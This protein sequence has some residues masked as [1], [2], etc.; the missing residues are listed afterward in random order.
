M[1]ESFVGQ[2]H[3]PRPLVPACL[4]LLLAEHSG[5]GYE[6]FDRLQSLGLQLSTRGSVY[7]YLRMLE[8]ADLVSSELETRESGPC[9]IVYRPTAV[10]S[11]VVHRCSASGGQLLSVLKELLAP[12]RGAVVSQSS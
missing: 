2:V 10:G 9:R 5:H 8:A 11:E 7:R 4:L 12:T 3:R 1:V 6:L